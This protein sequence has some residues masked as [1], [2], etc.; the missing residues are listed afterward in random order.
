MKETN[1]HITDFLLQSIGVDISKYDETF[2]H[3]SIQKRMAETHSSSAEEYYTYLEQNS[4]EGKHFRESLNISYSEFF[5]NPLTYATLERIV[6]PSIALLKKT[7]NRKEI[8]IWSA[9]CAA[10]QEPYSL[11]MLLEELKNGDGEKIKYRIFAS[12]QNE[13]QVIEAQKGQ[14]SAESLN[15]LSLRRVKQWFTQQGDLYTIKQELKA[16]IDFSVFDLFSE[17]LSCPA[18]SIFGDFDLVVCANLLFYYKPEYQQVILEKTGRCRAKNGYFISG[19]TERDI[20]MR[21]NFQE[22]FPQSGIFNRRMEHQ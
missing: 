5:R 17:K 18:A 15:N 21:H 3:K 4:L 13:A 10:G 14:Y 7:T 20:L 6:L 8:R 19:E 12:D 1:Q 2:L 11:A 16:N 9:A 22:V